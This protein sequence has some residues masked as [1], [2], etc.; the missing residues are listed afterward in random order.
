MHICCGKSTARLLRK[1]RRT[2]YIE[3]IYE[4]TRER[5]L[6]VSNTR[7]PFITL[8]SKRTLN[9]EVTSQEENGEDIGCVWEVSTRF[10]SPYD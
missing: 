6:E 2:S 3:A 7:G 9:L 10:F 4:S 5:F 8:P 1:G